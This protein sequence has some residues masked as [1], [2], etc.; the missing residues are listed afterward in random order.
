MSAEIISFLM[1]KMDMYSK[2]GRMVALSNN[3]THMRPLQI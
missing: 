3:V 2:R 1:K